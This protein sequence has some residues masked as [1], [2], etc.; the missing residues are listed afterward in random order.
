MSDVALHLELSKISLE[1]LKRG[2]MYE[3]HKRVEDGLNPETCRICFY[4]FNDEVESP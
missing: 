4:L 1:V 2:Y 3:F